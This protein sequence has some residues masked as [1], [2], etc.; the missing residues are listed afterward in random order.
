L[1]DPVEPRDKP[2]PYEPP[3]TAEPAPYEPERFEAPAESSTSFEPFTPPEPPKVAELPGEPV[4]PPVSSE[5]PAPRFPEPAPPA[6][7]PP[8]YSRQYVQFA[9]KQESG[10]AIGALVLSVLGLCTCLLA[11]PG[12]IMG[13]VALTKESRGEGGGRGVAIAAVVIG[14]AAMAL[15][16][17]F[18]VTFVI[19]AANRG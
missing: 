4:P 1:T 18:V 2:E 12:V 14:Y 8:G 6:Y 19:L 9:P 13:H 3:P 10:L 7:G 15:Y 17:A 16:I 5:N 11:L